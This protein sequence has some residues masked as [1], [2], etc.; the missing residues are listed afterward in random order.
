MK[1][2]VVREV[3]GKIMPFA[4][5]G[6]SALAFRE[7]LSFSPARNEPEP[8]VGSA[9]FQVSDDVAAKVKGNAAEV[10]DRKSRDLDGAEIVSSAVMI[11]LVEVAVLAIVDGLVVAKIDELVLG[12]GA[13]DAL[14]T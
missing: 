5:R 4:A 9:C 12:K 1:G 7:R 8:L 6:K 11:R 3:E 10:G 14:G 2:D 13:L